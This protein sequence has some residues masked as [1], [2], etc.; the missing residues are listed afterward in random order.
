[1]TDLSRTIDEACAVARLDTSVY[2]A[3]RPDELRVRK[4]RRR[5]LIAK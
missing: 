3:M 4:I 5:T 2:A 1:M